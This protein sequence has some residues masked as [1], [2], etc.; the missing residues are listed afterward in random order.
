MATRQKFWK[1]S[2]S[3]VINPTTN[4][5]LPGA[6]GTAW[7][8]A[9]GG[10]QVLDLQYIDASGASTGAVPSGIL[11]TDADGFVPSFNGP[12]DGTGQLWLDFGHGRFAVTAFSQTGM[13]TTW[14]RP[15]RA[16][17]SVR[18]VDNPDY[19][20]NP[21]TGAATLPDGTSLGTGADK[22]WQAAL[23]SLGTYQNRS[24]DI[25]IADGD[26][27]SKG[28]WRMDS[29]VVMAGA[30]PES[31]RI[32]ADSDFSVGTLTDSL[33]TG[34]PRCGLITPDWQA[35]NAYTG[36]RWEIRDLAL[37]LNS[38]SG[39]DLC[40]IN[41]TTDAA[42]SFFTHIGGVD[43]GHRISNIL[44]DRSPTH[45]IA[46]VV[47]AY[48]GGARGARLTNVEIRKS[49]IKSKTMTVTTKVLTSN[50]A[51]LTFSAAHPFVVGDWI[52]VALSPADAVFDGTFQ[53]TA[54]TSTTVSYAKTNANV[55]SASSGGT[56]ISGHGWD[57]YL[58]GSDLVLS[59]CSGNGS[60]SGGFKVAGGNQKLSLCKV[61]FA[62]NVS[63][64]TLPV[65]GFDFSSARGLAVGCEAQDNGG[66]GFIFRTAN[67][68]GEGL[69]SDSNGA[70]AS[71]RSVQQSSN[72]AVIGNSVHVSGISLTRTGGNGDTGYPIFFIAGRSFISG[73]LNIARG[74]GTWITS[75]T[76]TTPNNALT[77]STFTMTGQA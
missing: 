9:V 14:P 12:P 37:L 32:I 26:Y 42:P 34:I 18:S 50:V 76:S 20:V 25:L 59:G 49:G 44:I 77:S 11:V 29:K 10:T 41:Y 66:E 74:A 33:D 38:Y 73:D 61:F 22:A 15:G 51:T 27:H 39:L 13:F 6:T 43:P 7:T 64:A 35:A 54:V 19:L 53:I 75:P 2:S 67:W 30:G 40:G 16:L 48:S 28:P 23:D 36:G 4:V 71:S 72:Y 17:I 45:G 60:R 47:G 55:T 8:A 56:A 70:Y 3:G 1:N 21:T 5:L 62:G 31:T 68:V 46:F 58:D 69:N 57:F 24:G 52:T 63:P 65:P